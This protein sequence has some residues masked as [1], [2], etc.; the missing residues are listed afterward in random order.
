MTFTLCIWQEN[1]VT[2]V[3][4]FFVVF[5]CSFPLYPYPFSPG[6]P[7]FQPPESEILPCDHWSNIA[8]M[9]SHLR[10]G[11]PK[12]SLC[13]FLLNQL[14]QAGIW[15]IRVMD[16]GKQCEREAKCREVRRWGHRCVASEG[17]LNHSVH[18]KMDSARWTTMSRLI[19]LSGSQEPCE[20][21]GLWISGLLIRANST[22]TKLSSDPP[23]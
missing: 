12:R 20:S 10:W 14:N 9:C 4:L 5:F 1:P 13:G 17:F 6:A 15:V 22:W 3:W 18:G 8:K 23:Q 2:T 7:L 11:S 16:T 19:Y 21:A